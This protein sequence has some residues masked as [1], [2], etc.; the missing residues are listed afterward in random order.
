MS[1]PVAR[2]RALAE[3]IATLDEA[4]R[5]KLLRHMLTPE[6]QSRLGLLPIGERLR[7]R[8]RPLRNATYRRAEAAALRAHLAGAPG[9]RTRQALRA[10]LKREP[11]LLD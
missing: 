7:P 4:E 9:K 6:I 2:L 3:R 10:A 5:V 8:G 1:R 11:V